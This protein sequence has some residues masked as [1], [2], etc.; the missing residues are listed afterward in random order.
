[1]EVFLS[2][3][4]YG[5]I[6]VRSQDWVP[7]S[8]NRTREMQRHQIFVWRNSCSIVCARYFVSQ[9]S[10]FARLSLLVCVF[11]CRWLWERQRQSNTLTIRIMCC[12]LVFVLLYSEL[13]ELATI[14]RYKTVSIRVSRIEPDP[15]ILALYW[16]KI[17]Q[18]KTVSKM[19]L[20]WGFLSY[21]SW[22]KSHSPR[23][24]LTTE[25]FLRFFSVN[26]SLYYIWNK[27]S[28]LL[29]SVSCIF[30]CLERKQ[31]FCQCNFTI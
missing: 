4:C 11:D 28:R 29:A 15:Y 20:P 21:Y 2:L 26:P 7:G 9:Y 1:M 10:R 14:N 6:R 23:K 25:S 12:S 13:I 5:L 17:F 19:K 3:L 30:C 18:G 27:K 24:M 8:Q 16:K 22:I 31:I